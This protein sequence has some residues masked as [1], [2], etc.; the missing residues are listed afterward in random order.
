MV[1]FAISIAFLVVQQNNFIEYQQRKKWAEK[2]N[3]QADP[4]SENLLKIATTNF[5]DAFL[6]T[7]F[8]ALNKNFRTSL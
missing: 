8:I 3:E 4:D 1:F 2:L 7:N 5:N 6:S